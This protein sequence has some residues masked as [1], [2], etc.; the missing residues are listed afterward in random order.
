MAELTKQEKEALVKAAFPD[1]DPSDVKW[2]A[3]LVEK[4]DTAATYK[5]RLGVAPHMLRNE[6]PFVAGAATGAK[7]IAGLVKSLLTKKAAT[8]A[9]VEA[10]KTGAKMSLK[11]KAVIGAGVLAGGQAAANA[12]SSKGKDTTATD[13]AI[14]SQ[15]E[16]AMAQAILNAD[17]AGVD[18]NTILQS[19]NAQQLNLNSGNLQAFMAKFGLG[20]TGLTGIGNVG[21]FTGTET[22]MHKKGTKGADVPY[23]KKEIVS[24]A[25]WNKKFPVDLNG[26][27]AAK[28]K[29]VDAGVLSPSDGIDQVKAAWTKYGQLSLDYSRA[30]NIVSPWDLLKVQKGLSGSGSSTNITY[31]TS[32]MA[33]NDVKTLLKRQMQQSLGLANIDDKMFNDFLKK[34]RLKESK[35]PTKTVTTTTGKVTRRQTTPGYGQTDVLADAEAFA[36]Q[37]PRYAEFQTANVF[38]NALV[39]ALGL[40]A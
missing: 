22:M 23:L 10:V 17:A 26:I 3:M 9:G 34:V 13:A 36:K 35:N 37:D 7:A 25:E 15:S 11:K 29:F 27:A 16:Q 33:E 32:P 20:T 24:L 39:Q 30:G 28:Q 2:A 4:G 40:K 19:T 18:V 5:K 38:G 12:F 6:V 14:Q 8:E 1:I 21:I 31:D